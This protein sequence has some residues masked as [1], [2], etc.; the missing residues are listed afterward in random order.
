MC[1]RDRTQ[2][3]GGGGTTKAAVSWLLE[4]P[5]G[6]LVTALA[7]CALVAVG[8]AQMWRVKTDRWRSSIRLEDAPNYAPRIIQFAIFGRGVLFVLVGLFVTL[9]GR[10]G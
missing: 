3:D 6:P 8:V 5:F 9:A 1:I 7:G 4:Q 10:T 2:D